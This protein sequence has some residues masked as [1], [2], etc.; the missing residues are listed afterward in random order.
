MSFTIAYNSYTNYTIMPLISLKRSLCSRPRRRAVHSIFI[1]LT[2]I[3]FITAMF[4][5]VHI[6]KSLSFTH[7]FVRSFV[8]ICSIL[9]PIYLRQFFTSSFVELA[10][11]ICI[12][13]FASNNPIKQDGILIEKMIIV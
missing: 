1:H 7:S 13:L 10:K 4:I 11:T 2:N 6:L 9:L 3:P 5:Q 8:R 12:Q